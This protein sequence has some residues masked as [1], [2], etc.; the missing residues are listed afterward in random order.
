M[1]EPHDEKER[2]RESTVGREPRT[3]ETRRR[4]SP[5]TFSAG[6]RGLG[7]LAAGEERGSRT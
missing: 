6:G 3:K 2:E 1:E 7:S 4:E 5:V